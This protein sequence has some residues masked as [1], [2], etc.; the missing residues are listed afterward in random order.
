MRGPK[1]GPFY[2]KKFLKQKTCENLLIKANLRKFLSCFRLLRNQDAVTGL[3][4]GGTF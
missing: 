2:P 4:R 1:L 3:E